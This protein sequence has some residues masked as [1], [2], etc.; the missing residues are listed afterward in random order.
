MFH[1]IQCRISS[2]PVPDAASR[3]RIISTKLAVPSGTSLH[4][5]AGEVSGPACEYLVGIIP[6]SLQPVLVRLITVMARR[7]CPPGPAGPPGGGPAGRCAPGGG[8]G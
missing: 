3:S 8:G 7:P 2:T 5:N 6:P 4:E 1:S